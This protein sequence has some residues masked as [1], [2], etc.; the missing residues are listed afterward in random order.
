MPNT[1]F[2]VSG[3]FV[4][5]IFAKMY[6]ALYDASPFG[7]GPF[8]H[9]FRGF[10]IGKAFYGSSAS[11]LNPQPLPP[12]WLYA[13]KLADAYIREFMALNRAGNLL[14]GEVA[15]RAVDQSL[16]LMADIDDICPRWPHGPWPWP[17]IPWPIEEQMNPVE[18]FVFG[19]RFLGASSVFQQEKL[20]GGLVAL[21]EKITSLSQETS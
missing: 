12:R 1:E 19:T 3:R 7:G 15:K 11:D 6:P 5:A 9:L 10:G 18:L 16:S 17:P 21:G 8:E 13:L 20:S 2:R 4:A 14:G